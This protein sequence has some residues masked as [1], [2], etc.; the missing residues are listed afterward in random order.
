MK[1]GLHITRGGIREWYLND[2][3]HRD[4]GPAWVD[5]NGHQRWYQFGKPHRE[6]GPANITAFGSKMWYQ[7]GKYH[8]LDGPAIEWLDGDCEW[9]I[10]GVLL[11]QEEWVIQSESHRIQEN[12]KTIL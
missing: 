6:D 12:I 11:T 3:L 1:N 9:Y 8:R 4:D 10:E 2:Q 5:P 7:N